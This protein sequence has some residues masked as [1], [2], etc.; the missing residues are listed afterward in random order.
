MI[1]FISQGFSNG[2][3]NGKK[4]EFIPSDALPQTNFSTYA[5]TNTT[6]N[7]D[8]NNDFSSSDENLDCKISEL[9]I[10]NP[11]LSLQNLK[12][13][14]DSEQTSVNPNLVNSSHLKCLYTVKATYAYE[15]KEVDE[16]TFVKDD[17]IEVVEGTASEK[18][19]LDDGWLIGIHLVTSKRGLFPENFTKKI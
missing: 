17:I 13:V 14:A 4:S 3:S 12:P 6:N 11:D 19:E 15:A 10:K 8:N 18:E 9:E 5:N 1:F 2:L 7:N 16:L